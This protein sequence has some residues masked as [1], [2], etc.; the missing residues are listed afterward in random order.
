MVVLLFKGCINNMDNCITYSKSELDNVHREVLEI[1]W[2]EFAC[3]RIQALKEVFHIKSQRNKAVSDEIKRLKEIRPYTHTQKRW[4]NYSLDEMQVLIGRK[5]TDRET[6][7]LRGYESF[8]LNDLSQEDV[9]IMEKYVPEL[10]NTFRQETS[11]DEVKDYI[12]ELHYLVIDLRRD[13]KNNHFILGFEN[14]RKKYMENESKEHKIEKIKE[15]VKELYNLLGC[16][17]SSSPRHEELGNIL[18][19]VHENIEFYIPAKQSHTIKTSNSLD[20]IKNFLNTLD[21]KDKK[22]IISDFCNELKS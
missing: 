7:H 8:Y 5:P 11:L 6:K 12:L 18:H 21:L 17:I 10:F 1:L 13:Y 19:K 20:K 3:A 15:K 4:E 2:H 16:N 22:Q 14:A 9:E